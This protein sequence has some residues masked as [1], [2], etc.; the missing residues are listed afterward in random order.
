M[1]LGA[2]LIGIFELYHCF[3][4]YQLLHFG[5]EFREIISQEAYIGYMVATVLIFFLILYTEF[6]FFKYFWRP[7]ERSNLGGLRHGLVAAIA[8]DVLALVLMFL[9]FYIAVDQELELMI[10]FFYH[11]VPPFCFEIAL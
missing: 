9:I 1:H 10:H 3:T 6:K 5:I 4:E 8:Y 11:G 7:N 2:I